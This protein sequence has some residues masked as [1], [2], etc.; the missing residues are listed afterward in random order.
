METVYQSLATSAVAQYEALNSAMPSSRLLIA[1]AR[2]PGSGKTT[3]TTAIAAII[4]EKSPSTLVATV[5]SMDGYHRPHSYLGNLPNRGEAYIWRGALWTFD[6]VAIVN[7]V[8]R[9]RTQEE[10]IYAPTFDHATKDLVANGLC[11]PATTKIILLEGNYLLVD[12]KAWNE[13]KTIVDTCW[14]VTLDQEVAR[15]RVARRHVASG[16]ENDMES[17]LARVDRNDTLN[18]VYIMEHSRQAAD[19]II[20]SVSC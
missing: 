19:V 11:I 14:L 4:N 20:E 18:G 1:V 9:L 17:A 7:L 5:V 15:Q 3:S 13:I 12:K 2:P 10:D 6:S 8:R 16:I